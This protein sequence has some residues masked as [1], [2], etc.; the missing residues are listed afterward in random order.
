MGSCVSC[1]SVK[2]LRECGICT[3]AVCKSC[4]QIVDEEHFSFLP[5][6]AENLRKISY[7]PA[8]FD[9]EVAPAMAEYDRAMERA[10]ETIVYM[11]A[12]SKE[13]RLMKRKVEAVR[14]QD[15]ADYDEAILR[16]AF[17]AAQAGCNAILDVSLTSKKV[18]SGSYQTT[19]W[20][21]TALPSNVSER[22]A[23]DRRPELK[24]PN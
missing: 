3:R 23:G 24:N 15:C 5:V 20:S 9:Q 6:V 2:S 19:T 1:Q 13:T 21:G 22:Q 17:L 10:R 7:C 8:C 14:V 16:L 4:V 12:Q 11:K 18:R